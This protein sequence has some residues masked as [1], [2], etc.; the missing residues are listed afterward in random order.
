MTSDGAF[1]GYNELI[2]LIKKD[3]SQIN[4]IKKEDCNYYYDKTIRSGLHLEYKQGN[5]WYSSGLP[6]IVAK[7][8]IN[9]KYKYYIHKDFAN[10]KIK[11]I[12]KDKYKE[13]L[14]S[15]SKGSNLKVMLIGDSFTDILMDIF[16]YSFKQTYR[17]RLNIDMNTNDVPSYEEQY[18]IIKYYDKTINKFHPDIIILYLNYDKSSLGR[19]TNLTVLE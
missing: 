17:I 8:L 19:L 12:S 2:N 14:Y 3:F 16:P 18:K 10:L 13:R 7:H 6:N 11:P 5:L 15:Y 9:T 4:K 1:I